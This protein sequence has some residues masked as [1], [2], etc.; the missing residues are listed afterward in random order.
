MHSIEQ[1]V[2]INKIWFLKLRFMLKSSILKLSV[3]NFQKVYKKNE[4]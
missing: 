3:Q 4:H 1:T 2:P